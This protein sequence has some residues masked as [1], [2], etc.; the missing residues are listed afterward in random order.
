MIINATLITGAE[1]LKLDNPEFIGQTR[2]D[3][4]GK[5]RMYWK[6]NDNFYYTINILENCN[7]KFYYTVSKL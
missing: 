7:D 3:R 1:Y 6:C 2:V 5:Y 4:D